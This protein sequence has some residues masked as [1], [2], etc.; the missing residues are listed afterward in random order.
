M[1]Y[2]FY[3][4]VLWLVFFCRLAYHPQSFTA[5]GKP[6]ILVMTVGAA[7]LAIP[8]TIIHLFFKS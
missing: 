7:I 2:A 8:L 3:F 4:S 5:N 6:S 1:V